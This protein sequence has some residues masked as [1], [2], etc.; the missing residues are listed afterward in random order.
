MVEE[1]TKELAYTSCRTYLGGEWANVSFSNFQLEVI[2]WVHAVNPFKLLYK[3]LNCVD[4]CIYI[5]SYT[6]KNAQFIFACWQ[7]WTL[8]N[9][10]AW[11][12]LWIWLLAGLFMHV[13]TDCLWL[14]ER[15]A[16]FEQCCRCWSHHDKSTAMFILDRTCCQEWWNNKIE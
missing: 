16:W 15:T 5:L 1:G 14:D 10:T 11:T 6:R 2:S 12:W 9:W 13:G 8:L 3:R 4:C 7:A